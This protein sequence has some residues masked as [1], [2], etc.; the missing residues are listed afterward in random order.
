MYINLLTTK[1]DQ[2]KK[3]LL[4]AFSEGKGRTIFRGMMPG[5]GGPER[6]FCYGS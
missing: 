4:I 5:T 6:I 3:L 1:Q 2:I